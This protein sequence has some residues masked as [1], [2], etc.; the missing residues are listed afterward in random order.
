MKNPLEKVL[1]VW[2]VCFEN[3]KKKKKIPVNEADKSA[4]MMTIEKRNGGKTNKK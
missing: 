1:I 4:D 2:T 3:N